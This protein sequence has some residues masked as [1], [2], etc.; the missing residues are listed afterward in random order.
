MDLLE[1]EVLVSTLPRVSRCCGR[2]FQRLHVRGV[3]QD[4]PDEL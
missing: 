2:W 3:F 1:I 4:E